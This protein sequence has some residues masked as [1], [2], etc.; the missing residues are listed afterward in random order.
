MTSWTHHT[1][2]TG[3][4]HSSTIITWRANKF[5]ATIRW[6]LF[7]RFLTK[8]WIAGVQGFKT[9]K[10]HEIVKT[11]VFVFV[12]LMFQRLFSPFVHS[13]T[14][15]SLEDRFLIIDFRSHPEFFNAV[16][17]SVN[18]SANLCKSEFLE[19]DFPL[20]KSLIIDCEI[21][22][23][24]PKRPYYMSRACLYPADP[25]TRAQVLIAVF[26][27]PSVYCKGLFN[28]IWSSMS[29]DVTTSSNIHME[30]W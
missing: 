13:I 3:Q 15:T 11:R 16:L 7:E 14:W 30:A 9:D 8:D 10:I 2:S 17:A 21:I 28:R 22:W 24:S 12:S 5:P 19:I 26:T 20:F 23:G 6:M 1:N 29:F 18:S 4:F 27:S 25:P